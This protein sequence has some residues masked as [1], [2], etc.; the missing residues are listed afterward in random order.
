MLKLSDNMTARPECLKIYLP[1]RDF[2]E[3]YECFSKEMSVTWLTKVLPISLP[4]RDIISALHNLLQLL[5]M[6]LFTGPL[7]SR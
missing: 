4:P 2:R 6:Y 5:K 3:V 7:R 1:L